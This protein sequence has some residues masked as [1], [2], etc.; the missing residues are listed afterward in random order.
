MSKNLS[1]HYLS[2]NLSKAPCLSSRLT[3]SNS[4]TRLQ[5]MTNQFLRQSQNGIGNAQQTQQQQQQVDYQDSN[6]CYFQNENARNVSNQF[7]DCDVNLQS[8]NFNNSCKNEVSRQDKPM[9]ITQKQNQ[10]QSNKRQLFLQNFISDKENQYYSVNDPNVQQQQTQNDQTQNNQANSDIFGDCSVITP[11]NI[12]EKQKQFSIN[13]QSNC[14]SNLNTQPPQNLKLTDLNY[15]SNQDDN[16]FLFT[17]SKSPLTH[18]GMHDQENTTQNH[19]VYTQTDNKTHQQTL[20][21]S[22]S[23]T[24]LMLQQSQILN[25]LMEAVDNTQFTD[26]C[27]MDATAFKTQNQGPYDFENPGDPQKIQLQRQLFNYQTVN[28]DNMGSTDQGVC[29]YG[30]VVSQNSNNPQQNQNLNTYQNSS[31]N[32]L[33]NSKQTASNVLYQQFQY[34]SDND[35]EIENVLIGSIR[36]SKQELIKYEC[37]EREQIIVDQNTKIEEMEK[38]IADLNLKLMNK[39]GKIAIMK[40]EKQFLK[41]RERQ[42]NILHESEGGNNTNSTTAY[43]SNSSITG[44]DGKVRKGKFLRGNKKSSKEGSKTNSTIDLQDAAKNFKASMIEHQNSFDSQQEEQD[45]QDDLNGFDEDNQEMYD[46]Y[47][48]RDRQSQ[49]KKMNLRTDSQS[50]LNK[51][52]QNS[53]NSSQRFNQGTISGNNISN[54]PQQKG[55]TYG[56][57]NLKSNKPGIPLGPNLQGKVSNPNYALRSSRNF[58]K[59]QP[60]MKQNSVRA[61][62]SNFNKTQGQ[63]ELRMS[64]TRQSSQNGKDM[65]GVQN[66]NNGSGSHR[67][68]TNSSNSNFNPQYYGVNN[69]DQ[70][71]QYDDNCSSMIEMDSP[72]RGGSHGFYNQQNFQQN[73]QI[74]GSQQ[75]F[76]PVSSIRQSYN[77]NPNMMSYQQQQ[78]LM[79]N[80]GNNQNDPQTVYFEDLDVFDEFEK[81]FKDFLKSTPYIE[82]ILQTSKEYR[83]IIESLNILARFNDELKRI[84]TMTSSLAD[85]GKKLFISKQKGQQIIQKN[86]ELRVQIKSLLKDQV[87]GI[88][89]ASANS[90]HAMTNSF[91]GSGGMGALKQNEKNS[92]TKRELIKQRNYLMQENDSLTF[93]FKKLFLF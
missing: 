2:Q 16:R 1:S 27:M 50:S 59:N 39:K 46:T 55:D 21:I 77:Q 51:Q 60:P 80:F 13:N 92:T 70:A 14:R 78:L 18:T 52:Q 45:I 12:S 11:A 57:Q 25:G 84:V 17:Q 76:N 79:Q 69:P 28:T 38:M 42:M 87:S 8:S 71:D 86:R 31:K 83:M 75:N 34:A 23:N 68:V 20:S 64:S 3:N 24:N 53:L 9:S 58:D 29:E 49:Y 88:N 41:K 19:L 32:S 65:F 62:S 40:L 66:S 61:S 67:G 6:D 82:Q 85:E 5:S 93:K 81:K 7:Q 22:Q 37:I 91:S 63:Q 35:N 56:I 4:A 90:H 44:G 10:W 72:T 54:S 48:K 33:I 43:Q 30:S 74:Y 73:Q 15:Q 36:P 89:T 47:E 26:T